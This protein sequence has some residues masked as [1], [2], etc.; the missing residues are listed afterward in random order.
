MAAVYPKP[1]DGMLYLQMTDGSETKP[2]SS[3][4]DLTGRLVRSKTSST[5]VD[6]QFFFN[7][8]SN[9]GFYAECAWDFYC[10]L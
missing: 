6:S 8:H 7:S 2:E 4:Y 3:I 5:V 10:T 9:F 1:T